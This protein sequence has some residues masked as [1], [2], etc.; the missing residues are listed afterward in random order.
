MIPQVYSLSTYEYKYQVLVPNSYHTA[1]NIQYGELH[2]FV[3]YYSMRII[4]VDKFK[5]NDAV[6]T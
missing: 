5:L 3:Q 1:M 6:C 4:Y 2:K